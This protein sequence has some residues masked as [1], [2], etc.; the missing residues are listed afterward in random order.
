MWIEPILH[1]LLPAVS[2]QD[3]ARPVTVDNVQTH[4]NV[5]VAIMAV[6]TTRIAEANVRQAV[7]AVTRV[8]DATLQRAQATLVE[9]AAASPLDDLLANRDI[10]YIQGP[11][12]AGGKGLTVGRGRR[13]GRNQR[14]QATHVLDWLSAFTVPRGKAP[15]GSVNRL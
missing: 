9:V 1:R 10:N 15:E 3:V 12:G 8:A 4:D 5:R 2:I 13:R 6:L 14:L 7:L 11:D